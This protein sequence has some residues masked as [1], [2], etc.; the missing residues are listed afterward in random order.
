MN[1]TPNQREPQVSSSTHTPTQP[2]QSPRTPP[3]PQTRAQFKGLT[4]TSDHFRAEV[5][6][7]KVAVGHPFALMHWGGAEGW[8]GSIEH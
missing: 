5:T 2:T 4:V 6:E 3:P 7:A 8:T 1:K